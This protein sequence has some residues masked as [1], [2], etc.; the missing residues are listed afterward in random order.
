MANEID[1]YRDLDDIDENI[2]HSITKTKR[3]FW[4]KERRKVVKEI[5]T[6]YPELALG[7]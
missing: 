4:K 6:N 1:L 3:D 2:E 7:K 5:K